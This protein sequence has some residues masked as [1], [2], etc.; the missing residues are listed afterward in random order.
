MTG[1]L[2]ALLFVYDTD[3]IHINLKAEETAIV[4]YQSM[5]DS[6]SNWGQLLIASVGAF[7]PFNYF[8]HLIYFFWNTYGSSTYENNED[9]KDF[10]I[11]VPVIDGS[12]LQIEHAAVGTAN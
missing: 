3:L 1:Y 12:Q 9:V 10:N 11:S 4:A 7:K 8:Y 2:A 5:Q 6:I